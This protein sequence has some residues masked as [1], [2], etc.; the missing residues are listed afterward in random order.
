MIL[1]PA[2]EPDR[3]LISLIDNIKKLMTQL[4]EEFSILVVDDGSKTEK[5]K[6]VF[7]ELIA[8]GVEV[9]VHDIN[10]GKG[11]ALK[12]GLAEA[13]RRGLDFVVTADADGQHAPE[14]IIRVLKAGNLK[15]DTVI[16]GK[17]EFDSNTP[18]RSRFG[19]ILT[20]YIFH[21]LH[22]Q[23]IKDTQ[24]GL[25]YIPKS[26][27]DDLLKINKDRYDFELSALIL[28][29]KSQKL[30]E[31]EIKTIYEPGNP[32]SH[33]RKIRDSAKI[34]AVLFR[35]GIVSLTLALIDFLTFHIVEQLT[36]STIT[37]V[38]T[39]R[40]IGTFGYFF[41][42]RGFVYNATERLFIPLL[43]YVT[44][45]IINIALL[46]PLIDTAKALLNWPKTAAYILFTFILFIFNFYI[47][48][49]LVFNE[50]GVMS[51]KIN[52]NEK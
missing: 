12:S 38:I 24:T 32:S 23:L 43:K 14:D 22:G 16:L 37:S 5:S 7:Q 50:G 21:L 19:N 25:R 30:Q 11:A 51:P 40:I 3:T 49:L 34:Y 45:V 17:R 27:F 9:Q 6:Q 20:A 26:C 28:F 46:V 44:L 10:K 41:M 2:F 42:A 15:G 39:A 1:I 13:K 31:L 36:S 52:G 29:A 33:F 4:G 48:K 8:R 18:F 35:G 47:Q